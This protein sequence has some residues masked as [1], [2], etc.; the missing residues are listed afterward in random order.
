[1]IW[2]PVIR[3][4]VIVRTMDTEVLVIGAGVA[5]C[6]A[7]IALRQAGAG[8]LL[9]DKASGSP[10]RFCGEF[11]SGEAL[12]SLNQLGVAGQ[13]A[14]LGPN[15]IRHLRMHAMGGSGYELPLGREGLGLSRRALDAALLKR[16]VELG[17]RLMTGASVFAIEGGEQSGYRTRVLAGSR[18]TVV[19]SKAVIGAYG[20]RSGDRPHPGKRVRQAFEPV[21]RRE[22]SLSWH[23]SGGPRGALLVSGGYCGVVG[24]EG[25]ETNVCLLARQKA[26]RESGGSPEKLLQ[27][28]GRDNSGFARRMS[29]AE[30]VE[31]TLMVIS[32]IP[33]Q[34]K[35]QV[36]NGVF[37]AGDSAGVMPPFLG[38][39]VAAGLR[40]GW[41][42]GE[43]IG[44][45]MNGE[46]DFEEGALGLQNLVAAGLPDVP[47]VGQCRVSAVVS[48]S[49][50]FSSCEDSESFSTTRRSV[51]SEN[52]NPNADGEASSVGVTRRGLASRQP[53]A[54]QPFAS[55]GNSSE[56]HRIRGHGARREPRA[57]GVV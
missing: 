34:P 46:L 10:Q 37:M 29:E 39:G 54:V 6:A 3:H 36:V 51:L 16:A 48:A 9:L 28:V 13:V 15:R 23:G 18:A 20:K 49:R 26:L 5:G 43:V 24:V 8:V 1:M 47:K 27:S 22:V 25:G 44:R 11:V 53:L 31:G 38:I 50:R 57:S 7:A 19:R 30:P 32:Q 21:R 17:A 33:F 4:P 40:S 45:W 2:R 55:H 42:C 35:Q 52:A 12:E 14:A 41:A 56:F